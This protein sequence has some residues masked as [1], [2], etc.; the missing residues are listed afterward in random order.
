MIKGLL[1]VMHENDVCAWMEIM[2]TFPKKENAGR[3]A[4]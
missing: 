1:K 4:S 3:I 2:M